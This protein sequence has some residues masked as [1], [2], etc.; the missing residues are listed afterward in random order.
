MFASILTSPSHLH[1]IALLTKSAR[2]SIRE[3]H[4]AILLEYNEGIWQLLF[5]SLIL[6]GMDIRSIIMV[7]LRRWCDNTGY[8]EEKNTDVIAM[9]I[10]VT[11]MTVENQIL[12][13]MLNIRKM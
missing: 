7:L 5:V 8:S 9:S 13:S 4:N 1:I 12:S 10:K 3:V 11:M 2:S 6:F